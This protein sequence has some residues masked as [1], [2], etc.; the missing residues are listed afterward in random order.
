MDQFDA[1]VIGSGLGGLCS[2]YIMAKEGMNVCVLEKNRQFGGSL[3][4]FSRDKAIFD[5]GVHYI[6]ALDEGQN[7]NSYF[8]YF[9]L[10]DKLH[11]EKLDM[12][13]YDQISFEGIPKIYKH[14]QGEQ[15]FI[16]VLS[17]EFPHQRKQLEKYIADINSIVNSFPLYN[18][19][20]G[21]KDFN[22]D[23]YR[24]ISAKHYIENLF[25]D[26]LLAKVIG[27]NNMLYAGNENTPFFVHA[28]VVHSYLQS[29]YRCVDG[30]SQISKYM[31]DGIRAL[32]GTVLNYHEVV[33]FDISNDEAKSV[34]MADGKQ[35]SAKWFISAIDFKKT[36]QIIDESHF[37]KVY[38]NRILNLPNTAA[39]FLLSLVMKEKS[40]KRMDYNVYHY[41]DHD[42]WNSAYHTEKDWP[43][44][45]GAFPTYTS[46]DP[47][48][49]E[50]MVMMAYM[51]YDEVEKWHDSFA[52]I[53]HH[54]VSR[55]EDYEEYKLRKGEKLL[56]LFE[57]RLPGINAAAKS[58]TTATPLTYRDY[59]GSTDGTAY[60]FAKD[61]R[62]PMSSFFTSR[63]KVKN[64]LLTGQDLNLHG[65]LG[66]TISAV[67]T[68]SEI[69]GHPYVID[70]IRASI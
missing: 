25:T 58:F 67:A 60:G 37:R 13:G 34:T 54:K 69:F 2:A 28:A 56:G 6:G 1:I 45:I 29:A 38:R 11:L 20:G 48:Y 70:K 22:D 33:A 10:M 3:Q 19:E 32:G 5:T 41:I 44:V 59:I 15:N 55:G 27:A 26:P 57:D 68:T 43:R 51:R 63:T 18:L 4:I 7:L 16:E 47:E 36:M 49:T 17:A 40:W 53:P 21:K 31:V 64:L 65:L 23:W 30:S 35:M 42:I 50:N 14:A 12:N 9:G 52:T 24:T 66:V 46:K 39:I 61:Y 8:K 62:V